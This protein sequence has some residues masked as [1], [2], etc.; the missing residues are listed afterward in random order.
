MRRTFPA[1][2]RLALACVRW[3]LSEQDRA[4][5]VQLA[6]EPLNWRWFKKIVERNQILPLVY[7]NLQKALIDVDKSESLRAFRN[8]VLSHAR[9]SMSQTAQLVRIAGAVGNAGIET[10]ALKG[11]TLA[12]LAYGNLALRSPGDIDLLAPPAQVP[13]VERV[14]V[15]L[16]YTRVE[17]RAELTPRRMRYYLR[18]YKHFTY[19][20][21]DASPL[22]LHWRLFHN[23]PLLKESDTEF[24][25]SMLI[26]V[27][28]GVVATL[29]KNELFL[30]L[31]VHGAIHGWPIL[32]WLADIGALSSS[33]S[34]EDL[35]EVASLA[36]ERGL[37]AE[38]QAA[39]LLVDLFLAMERPGLG[40]SEKDDLVVN[41]IVDMARRL[42]TADNYCLDIR[43]LPRWGMFFYDLR[44]RSSW[45]YR[46]EDLR[47]SLVLPDDW[48]LIDLPDMLF[49][50]YAVVRPVSWMLRHMPRLSRRQSNPNQT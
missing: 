8:T 15:G 46:S 27:G 11:V 4:E 23:I 42:L 32:K 31:C 36:A 19:S 43:R 39:L 20:M 12:V 10:I 45:R 41:R 13:D 50:L 7:H 44:L 25:S 35:R 22:E 17:P 6:G 40:A 21:E 47:R 18:Y 48:E 38:L 26:P 34:A 24:P 14:L 29:S 3:P 9:Q 49:P 5:I 28:A 33:M 37:T 30:Y 1:E 16:G 2:F